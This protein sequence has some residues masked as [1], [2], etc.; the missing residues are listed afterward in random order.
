[1]P[2]LETIPCYC[3]FL[4]NSICGTEILHDHMHGWKH[5]AQTRLILVLS[6]T[7][8]LV[9]R[10]VIYRLPHLSPHS[11]TQFLPSHPLMILL[12]VPSYLASIQR[13]RLGT[14]LRLEL[15]LIASPTSSSSTSTVPLV[16]TAGGLFLWDPGEAPASIKETQGSNIHYKKKKKKKKERRNP[17]FLQAC[18]HG[19]V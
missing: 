10:A 4:C 3:H 2:S 1:M 11:V 5:K 15:L 17:V 7:V 8:W 19:L 9:Q 6:L 14:G 13:H 16:L 12:P 18:M